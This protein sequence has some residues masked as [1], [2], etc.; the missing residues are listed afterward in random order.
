LVDDVRAQ[1]TGVLQVL[2][3]SSI[4]ERIRRYMI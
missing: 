4:L 1:L 3:F 2:G